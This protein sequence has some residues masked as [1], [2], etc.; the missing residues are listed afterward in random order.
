MY[1]NSTMLAIWPRKFGTSM[2]KFINNI[3]QPEPMVMLGRWKLTYCE[4]QVS[5]KIHRSNED[6][7]G[8]CVDPPI[9]ETSKIG[10]HSRD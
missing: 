5:K 3:R 7:C 4:D 6:H 8:I 10:H 9:E 2:T 1:T